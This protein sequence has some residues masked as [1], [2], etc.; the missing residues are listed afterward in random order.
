MAKFD[1]SKEMIIVHGECCTHRIES[2]QHKPEKGCYSILFKESSRPFT[3]Q[4][5]TVSWL[6]DP[7]WVDPN[8]HCLV[9]TVN[10]EM[11][12]DVTGIWQFQ[13]GS[14]KYWYVTVENG[15]DLHLTSDAYVVYES[16]L[17]DPTSLRMFQAYKSKLDEIDE[18]YLHR[19]LERLYD[20]LTFIPMRTPL[21][22]FLNP[23]NPKIFL[24]DFGH[25]T[26]LFPFGFSSAIYHTVERVKDEKFTLVH[27]SQMSD[28]V[29]T[30]MT[31]L[32]CVF[33]NR[34]KG[35]LVYSE[36]KAFLQAIGQS[37]DEAGFGPCRLYWQD[38]NPDSMLNEPS[39]CRIMK[40]LLKY[41]RRF[42]QYDMLSHVINDVAPLY[43]SKLEL[44]RKEETLKQEQEELDKFL[45]Q[46]PT[47]HTLVT[48]KRSI[49]I[50][51]LKRILDESEEKK[52]LQLGLSKLLYGIGGPAVKE[53]SYE[54][55]V[56]G[57]R[58][59][60]LVQRLREHEKAIANLRDEISS[61]YIVEMTNDMTELSRRCLY[62]RL[63]AKYIDGTKY[64]AYSVKDFYRHPVRALTDYPIILTSNLDA[65]RV[66]R[67]RTFFDVAVVDGIDTMNDLAGLITLSTS[68]RYLGM[69]AETPAG[70]QK[71]LTDRLGLKTEV[72]K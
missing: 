21:S 8:Y 36:D 17:K 58:Y 42:E 2:I 69:G 20:K 10:N 5:R 41:D 27:M 23:A 54:M 34:L 3:Y 18:P 26:L 65:F 7:Q 53:K 70:F 62:S 19:Q 48:I 64:E 1:E 30:V 60:Y 14:I 4:S 57:L 16:C 59:N 29:G 31:L 9:K 63:L 51:K 49:P 55:G 45:S 52:S 39:T 6:K 67:Q 32:S 25:P 61:S 37:M 71:T 15:E 40:S 47:A 50:E 38:S 56:R 12:E 35:L 24:Y 66:L 43:D 11:V 44:K 28:K 46:Y 22:H 33:V 68:C 13:E 72:Y